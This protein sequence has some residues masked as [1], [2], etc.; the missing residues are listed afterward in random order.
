MSCHPLRYLLSFIYI[1]FKLL[2][3]LLLQVWEGFHN[4][5]N[6]IEMK[7][8]E[9]DLSDDITFIPPIDLCYVLSYI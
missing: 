1:F 5:I 8:G 4:G 2:P 7:G 3:I 9:E 6:E